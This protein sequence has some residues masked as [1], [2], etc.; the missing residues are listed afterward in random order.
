MI[1]IAIC[2]PKFPTELEVITT[3]L[4]SLAETSVSQMA[5][6]RETLQIT[7]E[8]VTAAAVSTSSSNGVTNT[9]NDPSTMT[10][11]V[12]NRFVENLSEYH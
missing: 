6:Q 5:N 10:L 9:I 8:S 2:L 11:N 7:E 12:R 3:S 1:Y 4:P